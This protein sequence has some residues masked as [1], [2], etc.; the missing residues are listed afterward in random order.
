[1]KIKKIIKIFLLVILIAF[2]AAFCYF[3]VSKVK[4]AKEIKWG[5]NF[6]QKYAQELG[7]DWKEVYS[8][9]LDDMGVKNLKIA[10]HWDILA[11]EKDNFYF[12]DL[13]WQIN[14]AKNHQAETILVV[15]MKTSRWPECHIPSW[16]KNL[17]KEEQQT[18][19][20]KMLKEVVLRYGDSKTVIGWQVENEPFF[21][22]GQC[23]WTDKE[24]LKKEVALVHQIDPQR[25]LVMITDSGEG[26]FWINSAKIGDI[27][28]TTMYKKVWFTLPSFM[29]K[30]LPGWDKT[31]FYVYYP[32][33]PS[34]YG[35]KAELIWK[36]FGKKVVCAEFQAEPWSNVFISETPLKEQD[37]TMNLERFKSNIEFAKNTG[38]EEFYLWGGE[39]MYW[40]KEKQNNAAIWDEAKKLF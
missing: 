20:L 16:A 35:K 14:Q 18:E 4:S 10:A 13:D 24:F 25:R 12:N 17:S 1:M 38:L 28:G 15:G 29:Y 6:S 30:Y 5:M 22:F 11:P 8:A 31:G 26:S 19:I 27:V 40:M 36:F 9:L 33:P 2:L 23:P 7:F 34:F 39:W 37:K 32:F 21:P 3:F